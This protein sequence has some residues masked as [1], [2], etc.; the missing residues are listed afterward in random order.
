V[1]RAGRTTASDNH[2][3]QASQLMAAL[4][5]ET[6]RHCD[7]PGEGRAPFAGNGV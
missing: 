3:R 7:A 2:T 1:G 5:A 6:G 4:I